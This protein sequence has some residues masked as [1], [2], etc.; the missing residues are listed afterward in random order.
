MRINF[1]EEVAQNY[2]ETRNGV[3]SDNFFAS[4]NFG[5]E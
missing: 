3:E 5:R 1:V 2:G 4:V